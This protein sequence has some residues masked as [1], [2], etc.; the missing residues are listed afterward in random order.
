VFPESQVSEAPSKISVHGLL[1]PERDCLQTPL[2]DSIHPMKLALFCLGSR[3]AAVMVGSA[4]T[5]ATA[6]AEKASTEK[7][8]RTDIIFDYFRS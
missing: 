2:L 5:A 1:A 8:Y 4:G 6:I 3:G 7:E